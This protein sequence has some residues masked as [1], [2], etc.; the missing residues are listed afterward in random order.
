MVLS[1]VGRWVMCF[2]IEYMF[3]RMSILGV[4]VG[5]L[6]VILW[7]LLMLLCEKCLMVVWERWMLF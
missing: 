1:N 6:V 4:V 2:F 3:L 7:R 5:R